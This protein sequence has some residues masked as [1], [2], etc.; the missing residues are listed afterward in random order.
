MSKPAIIAT[1]D[2]PEDDSLPTTIKLIFNDPIWRLCFKGIGR[3]ADS[4]IPKDELKKLEA[5]EAVRSF[6]YHIEKEI[7]DSLPSEYQY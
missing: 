5:R 3:Y 6:V 2:V 1:V 7:R 4:Y